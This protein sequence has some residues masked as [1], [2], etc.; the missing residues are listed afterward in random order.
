[1]GDTSR[2]W[3]AVLCLVIAIIAVVFLWGISIQSYW[4]LA[5]PVLIGFLGVLGLGFW[6]GWTILTIKTTP[7]VPDPPPAGNPEAP[8]PGA[9]PTT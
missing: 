8:I 3:G 9:K 5:I 7:P 4:A 1:M 6:I 2:F